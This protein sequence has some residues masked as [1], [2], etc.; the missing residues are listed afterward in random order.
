MCMFQSVDSAELSC[1]VKALQQDLEELKSVN[2]SLRKENHNLREQ[3]N[4][5][6]NGDWNITHAHTRT[7][8]IG[9]HGMAL[10]IKETPPLGSSTLGGAAG[11][12]IGETSTQAPRLRQTGGPPHRREEPPAGRAEGTQG[13]HPH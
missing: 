12:A 1:S 2:A 5:A 11:R 4:T 3:L 6:K 7:H 8:T 9:R 13:Q 10:R